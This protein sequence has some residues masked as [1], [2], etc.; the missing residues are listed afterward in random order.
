MRSIIVILG[1]S[2]A[3]PLAAQ[4]AD[5]TAKA[6]LRDAKGRSAGSAQFTQTGGMIRLELNA[7]GLEPGPHGLHIHEVGKCEPPGFKSAGEHFNPHGKK[8]GGKNE[9]GA[10]AGDLPN[11][12]ASADGRATATLPLAGLSLDR[13]E[14][15]SLL[16]KNGSAIVIHAQS[17]DELSDPAGNSGD[18]VVCG[19]ITAP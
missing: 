16:D 12:V 18:R 1:F 11:L 8:H 5:E 2:L 13:G 9:A 14:K 10:H 3:L 7:T 17:D 19:V 15:N 4:A 6:E